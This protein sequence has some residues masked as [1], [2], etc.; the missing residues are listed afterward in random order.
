M[1]TETQTALSIKRYEDP[2]DQTLPW[3]KKFTFQGTNGMRFT[4][5]EYTFEKVDT[6]KVGNR[7]RVV[8]WSA[9][10][11]QRDR[12]RGPYETPLMTVASMGTEGIVL[13]TDTEEQMVLNRS[14]KKRQWHVVHTSYTTL[15]QGTVWLCKPMWIQI[16]IHNGMLQFGPD[17]IANGFCAYSTKTT[18]RKGLTIL[19]PPFLK[20]P[21]HNTGQWEV[22]DVISDLSSLLEERE[23][24]YETSMAVLTRQ[25]VSS[26]Y[27]TAIDLCTFEHIG[28]DIRYHDAHEH[29]PLQMVHQIRSAVGDA[30]KLMEASKRI[31]AW[32]EEA[33][34][35]HDYIYADP[36]HERLSVDNALDQL[37]E[38]AYTYLVEDNWVSV[39]ML[40]VGE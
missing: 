15:I 2:E 25:P 26:M 16:S 32:V 1:I 12:G 8:W 34:G 39:A 22:Q 21:K 11:S 33:K 19:H 24:A 7:V 28:F 31:C 36:D 27:K 35:D 10:S 40:L 23:S 17:Q 14:V 38:Q 30:V 5:V 18:K 6:V 3:S 20:R 9:P 37:Y 29:D 4:S 13:K